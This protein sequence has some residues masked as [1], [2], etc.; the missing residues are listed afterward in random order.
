[1]W[2]TDRRT[3]G[4][5]D[6]RNCDSICALTAYA[7]ARKNCNKEVTWLAHVVQKQAEYSGF[8]A[9][10]NAVTNV[11]SL[12]YNVRYEVNAIDTR[13]VND[14]M[15]DYVQAQTISRHL[16]QY[17]LHSYCFCYYLWQTIS[18]GLSSS[19][20]VVFVVL[21]SVYTLQ[22]VVTTGCKV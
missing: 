3:D 9:K 5:T 6:G 18:L 15:Y 19:L 17:S 1:V 16:W 8:R 2:Q 11:V 10:S 20:F 7:V 22:P 14:W 21:N 4:Q 13:E 12:P